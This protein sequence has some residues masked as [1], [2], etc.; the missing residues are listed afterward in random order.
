MTISSP[1]WSW[2]TTN[3]NHVLTIV[4]LVQPPVHV[5][6]ATQVTIYHNKAHASYVITNV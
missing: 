5:P 2:K 1:S 4:K 3:V 6:N